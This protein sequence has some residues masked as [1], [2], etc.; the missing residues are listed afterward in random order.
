MTTIEIRHEIIEKLFQVDNEQVLI[1][2]L[3]FLQVADPEQ[4][5]WWDSL[6]PKQRQ[7]AE[8]GSQEVANGGGLPY[9]EFKKEIQHWFAEK[10]RTNATSR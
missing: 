9:P 3:S 6:T 8:T 4:G 10:T 1:Q 2:I 5:D 7:L